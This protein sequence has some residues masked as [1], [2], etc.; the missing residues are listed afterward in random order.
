MDS[1]FTDADIAMLIARRVRDALSD[2]GKTN[3]WLAD[4]LD[5]TPGAASQYL[6]GRTAF[7]APKLFRL[8]KALD[9]DIK[10][11]WPPPLEVRPAA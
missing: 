3:Q 9:L 5:V 8:A 2:H 10:V 4:L 11:F 1:E 7:P 6:S